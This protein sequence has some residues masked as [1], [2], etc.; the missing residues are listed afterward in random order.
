[1]RVAVLL[2]VFLVAPAA[3]A[4]EFVDA[5]SGLV[6]RI[7]DGW[8]RDESSEGGSI[9]LVL[10]RTDETGKEIRFE[11]ERGPA[12][13][14]A[15]D[16]WL[17]AQRADRESE[18]EITEAFEKEP[19]RTVGGKGAAGYN[20]KGK[21]DGGDGTKRLVRYRAFAVVNGDVL[22]LLRETAWDDADKSAAAA[23][24]AL[25]SSIDLRKPER[26]S[27]DLTPPE[28]AAPSEFVDEKGNFKLA[29]PAGWVVLEGPPDA[30]DAFVRFVGRRRVAD[31]REVAGLDV[32]RYHVSATSVFTQE[33]PTTVLRRLMKEHA[34]FAP[35]YGASTNLNV[36]T[37]ESV[38]LGG[39]EKSGAFTVIDWTEEQYAEIRKAEAEKAK[40]LR[41]DVPDFPKL[42][43]RGRIA[44][45]SPYVYVVRG[46][47][48]DAHDP[49]NPTIRAEFN[50]IF[51]SFEF[52]S[53]GAK[54]PP[55]ALPGGEKLGNTLDDA[56]HAEPRKQELVVPAYDAAKAD[57]S[58]PVS[59]LEVKFSLPPGF[60]RITEGI[61]EESDLQLWLAAQDKNNNWVEVKLIAKHAMELP[62]QP[63]GLRPSFA[64]KP[65]VYEQWK[66]TWTGKARGKFPNDMNMKK[67]QIGGIG[68]D[69]LEATG[70]IDGFPASLQNWFADKWGWRMEIN[71]ETRGRGDARL[72]EGVKA[73]LKG[74]RLAKKG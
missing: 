45:I 70:S 22:L 16:T 71:I 65:K 21:K 12:A 26:P 17:E 36:E 43:I 2:P 74:L 61:G 48:G 1:M 25:W 32:V 10:T 31:G 50:A 66:S 52:L 73:F 24:E 9:V 55:Y 34:L 14:F 8:Q 27:L 53:G 29:L 4:E 54:L 59:K 49:D 37:D 35:F 56:A 40:G 72:A 60:V 3:L 51:D 41:R 33:T 44:M 68:W 47:Y 20:V 62:V 28:G 6:V 42:V 30:E 5:R 13:D 7:P 57:K 38:L 18:L 19:A 23:L 39:V 64:D 11:A 63:N 69:G 67:K 15:P 46:H 58:K